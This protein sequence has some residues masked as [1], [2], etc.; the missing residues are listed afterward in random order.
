[1][2]EISLR[3]EI[4]DV[5]N[6]LEEEEVARTKGLDQQQILQQSLFDDL[7][8]KM[9]TLEAV[10]LL[11]QQE[12]DDHEHHSSEQLTQ[13]MQDFQT[14]EHKVEELHNNDKSHC[15]HRQQ[16]EHD[17]LE[18]IQNQMNELTSLQL[19]LDVA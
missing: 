2:S 4:K 12:R 3:Q 10:S 18:K 8:A 5:V 11:Q 1:M 9:E 6:R 14:L 7:A 16:F 13:H 15:T 19:R 17:V